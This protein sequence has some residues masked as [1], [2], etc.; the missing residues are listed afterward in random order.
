MLYLT[1]QKSKL[2]IVMVCNYN[3][4]G[5]ALWPKYVSYAGTL[6]DADEPNVP[7]C[8]A[9]NLRI[10][11]PMLTPYVWKS[12][13]DALFSTST[14][15]AGSSKVH[16]LLLNRQYCGYSLQRGRLLCYI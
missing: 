1:S 7:V 10:L 9:L 11:Q 3:R 13:Q 15:Q 4:T 5:G 6:Y 12:I 8:S 14:K 16:V 2:F